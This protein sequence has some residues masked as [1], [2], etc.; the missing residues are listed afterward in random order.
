MPQHRTRRIR[1]RRRHALAA[2]LLLLALSL[3]RPAAAADPIRFTHDIDTARGR[4]AIPMDLY[5]TAVSNDLVR[6]K[7]AG[8]LGRLQ[9]ALPLILSRV[10]EDTCTRRIGVEVQDIRPEVDSL[11]VTGRIQIITYRCPDREDLASRRRWF[12]NITGFDALM[13]GRIEDNCLYAELTDLS[14]APSGLVGGII[15]LL[16]LRNRIAARAR[17]AVNGALSENLRCIDLPARLKL[18]DTHIASGGFRDF[19]DG[20]MGFVVKGTIDVRARNLI[21]LISV[22]ARQND[23]ED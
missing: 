7:V 10:V 3:A 20:Q 9:A 6:V 22:L 21:A 4:I 12:S 2:A 13:H 14:V 8:N 11:R 19:G 18:L 5:L 16:G 1:S 17:E 15:N 23:L